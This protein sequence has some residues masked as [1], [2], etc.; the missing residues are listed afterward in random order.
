MITEARDLTDTLV[1]RVIVNLAWM[2]GICVVVGVPISLATGGWAAGFFAF[3][4]ASFVFVPLS[5]IQ[6]IVAE[7]VPKAWKRRRRFILGVIPLLFP[8]PIWWML[9]SSAGLLFLGF[10]WVWMLFGLIMKLPRAAAG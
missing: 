7:A 1:G 9:G 10:S 8:I 6:M 2:I 3:L 5:V 4:A